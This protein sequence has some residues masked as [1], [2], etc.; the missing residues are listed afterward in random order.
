MTKRTRTT[1]PVQS[2]PLTRMASLPGGF[3][4]EQ[5]THQLLN[6]FNQLP[7]P[8]ETLQ[9]LG[10]KR[11]D[12]RKLETDDEVYQCLEKRREALLATPWRLE[13]GNSR[14]ARFIVDEISPHLPHLMMA[15]FMSVPYG[16]SV[17][18]VVYRKDA[19]GRIGIASL[20]EKPFEWFTPTPAG[21]LRYFPE[22][23]RGGAEGVECHPYKFLLTRNK[24]TY[25]NP[26]GEALFSRLYWPVFFRS[27]GWRFWAQFLERFGTPLLLGKTM[28]DA[29]ALATALAG[30]AQDAVIVAG[31]NDEISAVESG[32]DGQ[33]FKLF[34]EA[35]LSR[36][37]KSILGQTL[38]SDAKATGLGSGLADLHKQVL[39][40]KRRAD[41][42]LV[43]ATVQRLIDAL[44]HFNGFQA[45][46]FVLA[47]DAGLER[48][49]AERDEI[50]VK[51]GIIEL[52]EDYLLD[53]YDFK[54]GDFKIPAKPEL[55]VANPEQPDEND[56]PENADT[57]TNAKAQLITMGRK[58]I[59]F[60]PQ[61]Q[62][63]EDAADALLQQ[64]P[65]P[66]NVDAMLSAVKA[67]TDPADLAVRLS[68]LLDQRDP[69][70]TELL[71]RAQFAAQTLGYVVAEQEAPI[72]AVKEQPMMMA[73][74]MTFNLTMPKPDASSVTV[75]M[76]AQPAPIINNQI[77]PTPVEI[78][79]AAPIVT[80]TNDVQPA[81]VEL[82]MPTRKTVTEIERDANGEITRA[83]QTEE[84]EE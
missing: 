77:N 12:L 83:V 9:K 22:D 75:Q 32:K 39:E 72:K 73:P 18:E 38:S 71:A 81:V 41:V 58:K 78:N 5:A 68:L 49:R 40:E 24:S 7:D 2:P 53:R 50:L 84:S 44:S 19:N 21:E 27:Q 8:D 48:D 16:Y 30:A 42:R 63:I 17:A 51:N 33:Q 67:A 36:I 14:A 34:E 56:T 70:F 31:N 35:I 64:V 37:Q 20:A 46:Q 55:T 66:I 62:A 11:L 43:T 69:R 54:P 80:V 60:T 82:S 45:P 65:E 29:S 13:P 1:P 10:F 74:A 52:T 61:Q 6:W 57:V 3:G 15:A 79:V 4:Q 26:Y 23:G 47:D 76:E 28:G 25:R 59:E